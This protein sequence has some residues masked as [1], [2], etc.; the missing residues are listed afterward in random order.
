MRKIIIGLFLCMF[1]IALPACRKK[2]DGKVLAPA[3][4]AWTQ[5]RP[6][7]DDILNILHAYTLDSD[8][9]VYLVFEKLGEQGTWLAEFNP[10]GEE[11]LRLDLEE[12][13]QNRMFRCTC[14]GA[15][16]GT[17]YLGC[18]VSENATDRAV[19][20]AFD[21]AGKRLEVLTEISGMEGVQRVLVGEDCLYLLGGGSGLSGG[22]GGEMAYR[23]DKGT[24][25]LAAV[26]IEN[27]MDISLNSEK[28]LLLYAG[29]EA[30]KPCL[31]EYSEEK[32]AARILKTFEKQ[33]FTYFAMASGERLVYCMDEMAALV[34]S[35]LS[36][37]SDIVT[38]YPWGGGLD[39]QI[40]VVNGRSISRAENDSVVVVDLEKIGRDNKSIRF[41]TTEGY[42]GNKPF[43]CGFSM[44]Y[45]EVPMDKLALKVLA[46]DKDFDIC[47]VKGISSMNRAMKENANFYPL[48]G[49]AGI[50]EY[51]DECYPYVREAA[52]AEDGSIWMLPIR[53]DVRMLVADTSADIGISW[54]ADENMTLEEYFGVLGSLSEEQ[55]KKAEKADVQGNFIC[56]YVVRNQSVD[57]ELFREKVRLFQENRD[58]WNRCV[59]DLGYQPYY[60]KDNYVLKDVRWNIESVI[61]ESMDSY[62]P[63][64]RVYAYP[65]AEKAEKN[66]G[67]CDYFVINPNSDHLEDVLSFLE[68]YIL[69]VR[70]SKE[71]PFFFRTLDTQGNSVLEQ[72][73]SIYEN[74]EILFLVDSELYDGYNEVIGKTKDLEGYI[75][76]TDSKLKIYFEE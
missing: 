35:S 36:S 33:E 37:F 49:V 4:E 32:N 48:D 43:S 1:C 39:Y 20:Y 7:A 59:I 71:K 55:A 11:T 65:K 73:R 70:N 18:R 28:K 42:S 69:Y 3:Q 31:L 30:G 58:V 9:N 74:A 53:M 46:M 19:L 62:G 57:T 60:K 44:Q 10:A 75:K 52:T 23:Y 38:V 2:E 45:T 63:D 5:I 56:S 64:A 61:R 72:V 13:F 47:L 17:L 22:S 76:E 15:E 41:L 26:G 34:F 68:S 40:S 51:F 24:K 16:D 25:E 12:F 8:G 27:V 66:A 54:P 29:A 50:E 6:E 67:T 14:I 21:L